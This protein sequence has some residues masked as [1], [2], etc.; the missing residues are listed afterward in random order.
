MNLSMP[1]PLAR[2]ADRHWRTSRRV[3]LTTI[4]ALVYAFMLAPI[5]AV[6]IASFDGSQTFYFR[7][8][9]QQFS[10]HWYRHLPVKYLHSLQTSLIVGLSAALIS[11]VIGS[12][13]ALG[14]VRGTYRGKGA[15]QSF[16]RLPLQVPS[17]VTGVVFLQ[18]YYRLSDSGVNL[19]DTLTGLIIA[20]VF[21]TIP[22]AVG[23]VAAVLTRLNP[24]LEE[25]AQSLGATRWTIFWRVV[26]P[27]MKPGVVAGFFYAFIV[28]FGDVPVT[29][30]LASDGNVTFPVQVFQSLQFDFEPVILALSTLVVVLSAAG[31][32]VMQRWIG[33]SLLVPSAGRR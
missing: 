32:L 28:S 27:A 1:L 31:I 4:T 16:F 30:F 3:V 9:P 13:A 15:L 23:T 5:L 20:H 26:F 8:P 7:F 17:V 18:F 12:M 6:A 2:L 22:Y 10:L 19:I 11:T 25:A 33:L 21:F 29:V 14:I 24:A